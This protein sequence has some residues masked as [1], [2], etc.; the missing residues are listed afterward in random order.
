MSD[1]IC[2]G[3]RSFGRSK[4]SRKIPVGSQQMIKMAKK[5]QLFRI[6]R[7]LLSDP[8]LN[9]LCVIIIH[10]FHYRILHNDVPVCIHGAFFY[11]WRN[12]FSWNKF[13]SEPVIPEGMS[14]SCGSSTS[15]NKNF[16]I[17]IIYQNHNRK[18]NQQLQ[19][20]YFSPELCRIKLLMTQ[21]LYS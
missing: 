9:K 19:F 12:D 1:T 6:S 4:G 3:R 18:S 15:L 20:H 17:I 13:I 14:S 10:I 2:S 16:S 8:E 5:I 21:H 7:T 11:A